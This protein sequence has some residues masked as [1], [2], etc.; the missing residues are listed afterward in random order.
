MASAS[1]PC[2][3]PGASSSRKLRHQPD[4]A[5][6]V[7]RI[8]A[9][10]RADDRMDHAWVTPARPVEPVRVQLTDPG[11]GGQVLRLGPLPQMRD[12]Q[13]RHDRPDPFA[14]L[15]RRVTQHP[16]DPVQQ[17]LDLGPGMP[18][19]LRPAGPDRQQ[20]TGEH[21]QQGSIRRPSSGE[22]SAA[23]ASPA[24]SSHLPSSS[25][26]V[27]FLPPAGPCSGT[28]AP[29]PEQHAR[30]TSAPGRPASRPAPAP[31]GPPAA[32]RPRPT[33]P[34]PAAAGGPDGRTGAPPHGASLRPARPAAG[35][36]RSEVR[37]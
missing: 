28:R 24:S 22:D 15:W 17:H 5:V 4:G 19:R 14:M 7:R 31:A 3:Y 1:G 37:V 16:F 20:G 18:A 26:S 21:R 8:A 32:P 12:P 10:L 35:S 34:R 25:W 13:H 11:E 36:G 27:S 30:A 2:G 6:Q 33:G 9:G 29:W 23:S